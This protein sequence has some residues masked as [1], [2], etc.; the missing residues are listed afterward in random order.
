MQEPSQLTAQ[1]T[2]FGHYES[3]WTSR[4]ARAEEESGIKP[5]DTVC[6][7]YRS[8][9]LDIF[10]R[11]REGHTYMSGEH[12]VMAMHLDSCEFGWRECSVYLGRMEWYP[13]AMV[14]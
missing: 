5:A 2:P 11:V 3:L 13:F 14:L 8:N 12:R 1:R 9:Q 7:Q 10:I 6:V 4:R